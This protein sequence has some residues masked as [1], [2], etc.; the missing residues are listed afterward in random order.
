LPKIDGLE[1]KFIS[2]GKR[3]G[4]K[5]M[6]EEVGRRPQEEELR[7]EQRNAWKCVVFL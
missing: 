1:I 3:G 6:N 2:S 4:R 7:R 5:K